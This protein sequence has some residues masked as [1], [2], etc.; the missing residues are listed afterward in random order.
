MSQLAFPNNL[1]SRIRFYEA[2]RAGITWDTVLQCFA[3]KH[4]CPIYAH[5]QYT[6]CASLRPQA[7]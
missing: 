1:C 3:K 5:C 2:D 7:Q 4:V 6:V